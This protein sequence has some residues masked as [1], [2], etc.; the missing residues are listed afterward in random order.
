MDFSIHS[1]SEVPAF[2]E[3][4]ARWQ[5][6]ECV[7]EGLASNLLWRRRR[8]AR[9]LDSRVPVPGTW[10]ATAGERPLGCASLVSYH[11]GGRDHHWRPGEPLWVSGVYVEADCR[12][13]GLARALLAHAAV[14][15]GTLGADSLWLFTRDS[16]AFYRRLGWRRV[17]L[18]TLA[19]H[20][21]TL[22]QTP[23]E[24]P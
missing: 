18:A 6:R 23:V 3:T 17:R 7:R 5:H 10:V 15:A 22:M 14:E 11:H 24:R 2:A 16:E 12:R 13:R 8:L 9:H 1:L 4:I 19:G 21:V 20:A